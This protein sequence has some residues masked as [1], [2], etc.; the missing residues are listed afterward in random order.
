MTFSAIDSYS[1]LT[2]EPEAFARFWRATIDNTLD[3]EPM[4]VMARQKAPADGLTLDHVSYQSLGG[5]SIS[6]YLLAHD[7][8]EP[9]PLVVHSHGYNSQYD[10]MLHWALAGCHVFGIDFRGFGRSAGLPLARGGYILTGIESPQT[11]ILRGA[12]ADLVQGMRTAQAL[13]GWRAPRLVLKGFSFG[14]AMALMAAA[15]H[16][17]ADFL[18]VG[19]PTLGWHRERLRLARAGSSAELK[20]CFEREPEGEAAAM[21]TLEFFEALHFAAR[22][23]TPTLLGVGLDDEVVPSRSVM[24]IAN[25]LP[26]QITEL[27]I[28]PVAHSDDP[29]ESLWAEFDREWLTLSTDGLPA[30]FGGEA[31]RVAT[32]ERATA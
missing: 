18:V 9:R 4:P 20:A 8:A 19:Q 32:L 31:R 25:Q 27:R 24:A 13:L 21:R 5:Q 10:I 30:D 14:G 29:R 11:S 26:E 23:S 2:T 3:I 7:S 16:P 22:I 17:V 12:V 6:A 15:F 28:L 1:P